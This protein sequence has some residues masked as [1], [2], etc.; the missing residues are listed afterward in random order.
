MRRK[1][2]WILILAWLV[3]MATEILG[4]LK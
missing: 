2:P 1:L 3:F 4:R